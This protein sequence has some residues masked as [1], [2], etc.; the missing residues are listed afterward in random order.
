M[1]KLVC[2]SG[3]VQTALDV[4]S[5]V[6]DKLTGSLLWS[7]IFILVLWPMID[8]FVLLSASCLFA[9][10]QSHAG[11]FLVDIHTPGIFSEKQMRMISLLRFSQALQLMTN[12]NE[13][14]KY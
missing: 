13:R 4:V 6:Y 14:I 2:V 8:L 1:L 10:I 11:V 3:A 7:L 5:C 9:Q 12:P